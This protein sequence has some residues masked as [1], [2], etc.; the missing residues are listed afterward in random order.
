M[1]G[2]SSM[3]TA[4]DYDNKWIYTFSMDGKINLWNR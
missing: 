3:I 2:H 1:G 4:V